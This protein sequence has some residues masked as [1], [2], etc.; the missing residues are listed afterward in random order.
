MSPNDSGDDPKTAWAR[1]ARQAPTDTSPDAARAQRT[2]HRQARAFDWSQIERVTRDEWALSRTAAHMR[3][4]AE[5]LDAVSQALTRD[6]GMDIRVSFVSFRTLRTWHPVANPGCYALIEA[7]TAAP[8][9]VLDIDLVAALE[10]A[11]CVATIPGLRGRA[12]DAHEVLRALSAAERAIVTFLLL[13]VL[14]HDPLAERARLLTLECEPPRAA[15][16]LGPSLAA[17]FAIHLSGRTFRAR[18]VLSESLVRVLS[19]RAAARRRRPS[20]QR[21]SGVAI[22]CAAEI[23]RSSLTTAESRALS[24]GDVVLCTPSHPAERATPPLHRALLRAPHARTALEVSIEPT[25]D[26]WTPLRVEGAFTL[27]EPS[28]DEPRNTGE[29]MLADAMIPLTVEMGRVVLRVEEIAALEP[30][31]TLLLGRPPDGTVEL[32][33]GGK[34]LARGELVDVEGELGVRVVALR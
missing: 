21:L 29:E 34:I 30:G 5:A 27:E 6:L 16:A 17:D 11:A 7:D 25:T 3:P 31:D 24:K 33:A 14:S 20:L 15:A 19:T 4:G 23:A 8:P 26:A 2:P 10:V 9:L 18:A 12:L 32:V 28:M 1:P 22:P 13:R